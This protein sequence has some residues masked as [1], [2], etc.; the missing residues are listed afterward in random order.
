M[1]NAL[2]GF[3]AVLGLACTSRAQQ[4]ATVTWVNQGVNYNI[5]ETVAYHKKSVFPCSALGLMR[6]SVNGTTLPTHQTGFG[7]YPY[8]YIPRSVY[9]CPNY[10]DSFTCCN[11]IRQ[12][13]IVQS[14]RSL[15]GRPSLSART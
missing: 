13:L 14:A 1:K 15:L 5:P 4:V 10:L 12:R 6:T 11:L 7:V 8:I 9:F 2:L 3:L